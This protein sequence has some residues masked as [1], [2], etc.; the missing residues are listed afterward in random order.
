L[1]C[2]N[3]TKQRSLFIANHLLIPEMMKYVLL[4][5]AIFFKVSAFSQDVRKPVTKRIIVTTNLMSLLAQRPTI[6]VQKL[7]TRTFGMEASFV[8]GEV[9]N[10]LFTDHYDYKGVLVRAK[11]YVSELDYGRVSPYAGLY[12]GSLKRNIQ[13]VGRV[14]N[15]GFFGYPD[16]N[17]SANSIRTGGS[18][19][20][21][22]IGKKRLVLDALTSIGYGR[23]IK[24][25]KSDTNSKG[26]L[27]LQVWLSIG[28]CF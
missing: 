28:Y 20:L 19:G 1:K 24:Y 14:D 11:I 18:L 21:T 6:T 26:Y 5:S 7:F 25:Y 13:T 12:V 4:I 23:Y 16:R 15:T 10:F 3:P 8:Q 17:F 22:F 9:N 27:D 2:N